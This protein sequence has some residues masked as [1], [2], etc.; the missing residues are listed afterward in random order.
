MWGPGEESQAAF[1]LAVSCCRPLKRISFWP[2]KGISDSAL[3]MIAHPT[4]VSNPL[5]PFEICKEWAWS[6]VCILRKGRC[7]AYAWGSLPLGG[8]MQLLSFGSGQG[9]P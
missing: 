1:M 7:Y 3:S 5:K 4:D 8:S 6:L 9:P 2:F